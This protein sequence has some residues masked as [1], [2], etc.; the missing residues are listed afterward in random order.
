MSTPLPGGPSDFKEVKA[1][2]VPNLGPD[3]VGGLGDWVPV[4]G[5]LVVFLDKNVVRPAN[6]GNIFG[7]PH[8]IN[9]NHKDQPATLSSPVV[10]VPG[11]LQLDLSRHRRHV[12]EH[13]QTR[14]DAVFDRKFLEVCSVG[15]VRRLAIRVLHST[16]KVIK[17]G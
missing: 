1:P 7:S 17:Q 12:Q 13:F 10:L 2:L 16:W 14:R 4:E 3:A 9:A 8:R 11:V 5:E 15:P 6:D